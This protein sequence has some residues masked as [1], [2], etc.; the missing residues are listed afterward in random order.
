MTKTLTTLSTAMFCLHFYTP[1][2]ATAHLLSCYNN[3]SLIL[4]WEDYTSEHR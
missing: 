3:E 4:V 1:D 2:G